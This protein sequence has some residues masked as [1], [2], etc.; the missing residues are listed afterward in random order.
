MVFPVINQIN[1]IGV[2]DFSIH[3]GNENVGQIMSFCNIDERPLKFPLIDPPSIEL[4]IKYEKKINNILAS[5]WLGPIKHLIAK[6][7]KRLVGI[8]EYD[9]LTQWISERLHH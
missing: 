6:P 3:G 9:S 8:N 4:D 7:V 1:N 2:D 5:S